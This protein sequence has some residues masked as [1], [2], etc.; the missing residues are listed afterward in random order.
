L[1]KSE[2]QEAAV[3]RRLAEVLDS[4][5]LH[6]EAIEGT[7]RLVVGERRTHQQRVRELR[8][9]L[10]AEPDDPPTD[11]MLD[12]YNTM[13]R[14]VRGGGKDES[15]ADLNDRLRAVFEEFRLERVDAGVVGVLPILRRDFIDRYRESG[16]GSVMADY[17][18]VLRTTNLPET[19]PAVLW[20]TEPPPVKPLRVPSETGR[21]TQGVWARFCRRRATAR[22]GCGRRSRANGLARAPRTRRRR[23][24]LGRSSRRRRMVAAVRGSSPTG[25]LWPT[26]R[27]TRSQ[28]AVRARD[29]LALRPGR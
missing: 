26:R 24:V 25:W 11:A 15:I 28:R 5:E 20:A 7:L 2:R 18:Q 12:I 19:S 27:R 21:N 9:A 23:R 10:A 29:E 17:E 14:A 3:Q 16:R 8:E 1:A 13:A 6:R 22:S 4:D